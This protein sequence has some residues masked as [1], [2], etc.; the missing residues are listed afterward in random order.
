VNSREAKEILML[1]RPGTADAEDSS[2]AEALQECGRDPEL[3]R[4]FDE[5]CAVYTA[6]RTRFKEAGVPEAL[7]E[8]II[9]ERRVH[10]Q[11]LWRKAAV[12]AVGA[13]AVI[14]LAIQF[15][16]NPAPPPE[17][18]DFAAYR[19]ELGSM[20]LRAYGMQLATNDLDRIRE[21]FQSGDNGG[22]PNYTVPE[23]LRQNAAAAGCVAFTWQGKPVSMICFLSGKPLPQ[24]QLSDLWLFV[25][26]HA[27]IPDAPGTAQPEIAKVNR[28]TTATW[29]AN[30]KTYVLAV[31]G[32]EE[33]LRKFL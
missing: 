6:L 13:I 23:G 20:A 28:L 24:G 32:D 12:L 4:W 7:K 9:A 31:D 29:T 1:Y 11:P 3:K 21:F 16:P 22:V 27:S 25:T 30:G 18:H 15:W 5:H 10:T 19:T 17:P 8:Q 2:F 26:D 14:V 33:F